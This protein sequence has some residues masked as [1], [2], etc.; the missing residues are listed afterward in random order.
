MGL[1]K[2]ILVGIIGLLVAAFYLFR[3]KKLAEVLK[4]L[5]LSVNSGRLKEIN[6]QLETLKKEVKPTTE[7]KNQISILKTEGKLIEKENKTLSTS[8]A[9][10]WAN[11]RFK[12][13]N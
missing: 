3:F 6:I 5:T 7:L 12:S 4:I 10:N 9:V 8:D 13:R 2:L 1:Q 11:A